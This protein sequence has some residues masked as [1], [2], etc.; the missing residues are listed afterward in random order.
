MVSFAD[1]IGGLPL[2]KANWANEFESLQKATAKGRREM[3]LGVRATR[4]VAPMLDAPN[5]SGAAYERASFQANLKNNEWNKDDVAKQLEAV[6]GYNQEI[7]AQKARAATARGLGNTKGAAQLE[8]SVAQ[9]RAEKGDLQKRLAAQV[10]ERIGTATLGDDTQR[11]E[12]AKRAYAEL[13]TQQADELSLLE[14][15]NRLLVENA[16]SRQ[17]VERTLAMETVRRRALATLKA[18]KPN[19]SPDEVKGFEAQAQERADAEGTKFDAKA[20]GERI[21][22]TSALGNEFARNVALLKEQEKAYFK[23]DFGSPA[24][25]R[26][27]KKLEIENKLSA[28]FADKMKGGDISTLSAPDRADYN[29]QLEDGLS[30]AEAETKSQAAQAYGERLMAIKRD[31]AGLG[32]ESGLAAGAFERLNGIL[33]K[34]SPFRKQ[35]LEANELNAAIAKLKQSTSEQL[36]QKAGSFEDGFLTSARAKVEREIRDKKAAEANR[37]AKGGAPLAQGYYDEQDRQGALRLKDADTEDANARLVNSLGRQKELE[38]SIASTVGE[39]LAVEQRYQDLLR[40]RLNITQ[41]PGAA[42]AEASARAGEMS[43][44]RAADAKAR[45]AAHLGRQKDLELSMVHTASERL[46]IEQRYQDLLRERLGYAQDP[47]A[48]ADDAQGRAQ[49]MA[50]TRMADASARVQK[51]AQE[52]RDSIYSGLKE[53]FSKG[54]AAGMRAFGKSVYERALDQQL[55]AAAD[56]L[57]KRFFGLGTV[58]KEVAAPGVAGVALPALV[59]PFVPA[60]ARAPGIQSS[61]IARVAQSIAGA[62]GGGNLVSATFHIGS[63]NQTISRAT[64]NARSATGASGGGAGTSKSGDQFLG[65]VLGV[66]SIFT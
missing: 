58:P 33:S 13:R 19:A 12:A 32:D 49:E 66:A 53:G 16:Q 8:K 65:D 38:L 6:K 40:E 52:M 15:E 28:Q 25:A 11:L 17:A 26:Q 56:N 1:A 9:L 7:E 59:T 51:H 24:L 54:A 21:K 50:D 3:S 34:L 60:A 62:K 23:Y 57:G 22:Q 37:I 20:G 41:S 61:P 27:L 47:Q 30:A 39:K 14:F 35:K 48:A 2:S 10:N 46:A 42:Q 63:A 5:F 36:R 29:K 45:L 18:G 64:I 4:S 44:A 43:D 31:M 55:G